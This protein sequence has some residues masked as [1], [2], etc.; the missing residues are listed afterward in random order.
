M[1]TVGLSLGLATF[2]TSTVLTLLPTGH[3]GCGQ[4][5]QAGVW[6]NRQEIGAPGGWR[7][8]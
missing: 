5:P 4:G 3:D 7:M 1:K 8:G 2:L 6:A